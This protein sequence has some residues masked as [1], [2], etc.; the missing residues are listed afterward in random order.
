M[1]TDG[2]GSTSLAVLAAL[3]VAYLAIGRRYPAFE[4]LAVFAALTVVA[5]MAG[6]YLPG[7]VAL[8]QPLYVIEGQAHGVVPGPIVPPQLVTFLAVM[9]AFGALFGVGGFSALWG[10]VRPWFWAALSAT[11]PLVLLAVAFWRIE[12]FAVDLTWAVVAFGLAAIGVGAAERVG[13][14]RAAPDL[15]LALGVYAAG[16]VAALSLAAAM[17][18]EQ[19]WLTV[20]LALELPALAWI[21]QRLQLAGAAQ[22]GAGARGHR[23]GP[24]GA[25]LSASWTIRSE[26]CPL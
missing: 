22:A 20:V 17:A 1:R 8:P 15:N 7:M 24:A 23:P 6:W 12:A 26:R 13:R 9:S 19:A 2:Y 16:V 14:Y 11:I 10:A 25:R 18:L 5:A 21:A 4:A 3:A